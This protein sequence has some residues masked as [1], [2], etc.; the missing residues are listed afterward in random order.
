M[1]LAGDDTRVPWQ[2]R[3]H[4]RRATGRTPRSGGPKCHGYTSRYRHVGELAMDVTHFAADA[5][6]D[7]MNGTSF[8]RVFLVRFLPLLADAQLVASSR[9]SSIDASGTPSERSPIDRS[10]RNGARASIPF[11]VHGGIKDGENGG[12]ERQ[13]DMRALKKQPQS[14]CCT[15]SFYCLIFQA[16]LSQK[17]SC[18][19]RTLTKIHAG[20]IKS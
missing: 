12:T 4:G 13:F 6:D 5:Y 16:S 9:S 7:E 3:R 15:T 2:F 8:P 11:H 14:W 19:L 20:S 18:H 10:S 1:G 17:Y